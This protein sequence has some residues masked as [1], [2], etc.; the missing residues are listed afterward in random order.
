MR[1]AKWLMVV[2]LAVASGAQAQPSAGKPNGTPSGPAGAP[3]ANN[4]HIGTPHGAP[5]TGNLSPRLARPG[6]GTPH[7]PAPA[8]GQPKPAPIFAPGLSEHHPQ[9]LKDYVAEVR[10]TGRHPRESWNEG[11]SPWDDRKA[12]AGSSGVALQTPGWSRQYVANGIQFQVNVGPITHEFFG[13]GSRGIPI[14]RGQSINDWIFRHEYMLDRYGYDSAG[15]LLP[16][17]PH[18][19]AAIE[20]FMT[21]PADA[22][23]TYDP[24]LLPPVSEI[25]TPELTT[26]L[27]KADVALVS[28]NAK[29][30]IPLYEEH[31]ASDSDDAGARVRMALA[32]LETGRVADAT[33]LLHMTYSNDPALADVSL[34]SV[35]SDWTVRRLR[36]VVTRAVGHANRTG[37]ASAWMTAALLMEAE[38]RPELAAK[39]L[40]KARE[41][42]LDM[43]LAVRLEAMVGAGG[44]S[45]S[46]PSP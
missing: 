9:A 10:R 40:A 4:L 27:A 37:A 39:M 34:S 17:R 33:A 13:R 6:R 2:G 3:G 41:A 5:G 15:G 36:N 28:G 7:G 35:V 18:P 26:P 14:G 12:L 1:L 22:G 38:G 43:N 8:A 16:C 29:K 42:G 11:H 46:V 30:A 31:L 45:G 20:G 32:M 24:Q 19:N 23:M 25:V 21:G 44:S